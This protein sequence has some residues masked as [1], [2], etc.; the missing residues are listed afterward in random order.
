MQTEIRNALKKKSDWK[1]KL[2][3]IKFTFK[4]DS[5]GSDGPQASVRGQERDETSTFA[6]HAGRGEKWRYQITISAPGGF[7]EVLGIKH[8]DLRRYWKSLDGT[9]GSG[10]RSL[11][12]A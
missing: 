1:G 3:W 10:N 7:S 9:D 6:T 8:D 12:P 5:R 2:D 11:G 4:R